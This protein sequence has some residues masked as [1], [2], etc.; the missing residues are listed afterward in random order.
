MQRQN[1]SITSDYL[2]IN[3]FSQE[4]VIQVAQGSGR[5]RKVLP[6]DLQPLGNRGRGGRPGGGGRGRGGYRGGDRNYPGANQPNIEDE[7]AFPSLQAH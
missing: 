6:I 2:L 7:Q 3:K 5:E 4:M 1:I